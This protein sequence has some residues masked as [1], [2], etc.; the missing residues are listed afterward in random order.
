[1]TT[2]SLKSET[3][4]GFINGRVGKQKGRRL[5]RY[6]GLRRERK[7]AFHGGIDR[8]LPSR[9]IGWVMAADPN[10]S[11]YEV[12]L[13]VG[14]HLI[15]RVEIDQPRADVC[16]QLGREGTPGFEMP[17]PFDLPLLD[18]SLPIRLLAVSADGSSQ[19]ELQ[20]MQKDANTSERLLALL[21]SEQRGMDGHVD[22]IQQ[23]ELM[24]WAGRRGQKQPAQIWLQSKGYQPLPIAC[25]QWREGMSTQQM[26]NQCGFAIA[27][28][29]LPSSWG[30][31]QIWCSFDQ[32]GQW[33]IPQ[34]QTL[35]V[36]PG[37][38][39]ITKM[40]HQSAEL[41]SVVASPYSA[42]LEAAPEELQQHWSAL[43]E[44]RVFLNGLEVEVQRRESLLASQQNSA[45]LPLQRGGLL[46]RL[47]RAR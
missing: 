40:V 29:A 37:A 25:E 33:Q 30:G 35:V 21:Q 1:L 2:S 39:A 18:W 42:Q 46:R 14:P 24:G 9:I 19:A 15:A 11:F 3:S 32:S 38:G 36:P 47:L 43:E 12:R 7:L 17:L 41:T 23:G 26:P 10:T 28:D 44:F 4:A 45:D 6:L 20:L 31:Q 5:K 34:D 13:L 8:L 16:E 27:V 22:G